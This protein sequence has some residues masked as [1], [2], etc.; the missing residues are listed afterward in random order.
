MCVSGNDSYQLVRLSDGGFSICSVAEG[1]TFHPVAGP[2]AEAEALY[3]RQLRIRERLGEC[4]GETFV[5]WDVGLGGAAN[6][7]TILR[8][9]AD[10]RGCI[11]VIS[12]DRTLQA[13]AFALEHV[14]ALEY[15][16]GF[17]PWLHELLREAVTEFRF[18]EVHVRWQVC[19]GD[20]PTVME[21]AAHRLSE[22]SRCLYSP[23]HAVFYDAFSP[24]VNPEMWTGSVFRNLHRLLA[25]G[26][27]CALATF[28]RS[29]M[30]RVAMLLAGFYVGAGLAI[31][32]KEETTVASNAPALVARPLGRDW[33]ERAR[34]SGSAE[35]LHE[36]R[37]VRS[38]LGPENW[39][40][41]ER[42][43]QFCP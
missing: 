20:F 22:R 29:T 7:L 5:I 14:E 40:R 11:E 36:A 18:R 38:P 27:P 37:H 31:A 35:P 41:L 10:I 6:V 9:V 25:Q 1:E 33:L 13:L 28:S 34:R 43:P 12:F 32:G 8:G 4:A 2:T 23:P 16:R 39:R 42:H 24:A 17:E 30:V 15:V 19:L 26:R 3:L 21:D